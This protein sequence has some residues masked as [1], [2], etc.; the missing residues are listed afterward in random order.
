[1]RR[2][3]SGVYEYPYCDPRALEF[4]LLF[5][6]IWCVYVS[7]SA[8]RTKNS[9]GTLFHIYSSP[10]H[11]LLGFYTRFCYGHDHFLTS[12]ATGRL[13]IE[14]YHSLS[15]SWLSQQEIFV[16]SAVE[17]LSTQLTN[18]HRKSYRAIQISVRCENMSQIF[19]AGIERINYQSLSNLRFL[20]FFETE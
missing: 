17:Q 9:L 4:R 18:S 1:M 12:R 2:C 5:R 3:V 10:S 8:F 13:Q 6:Y 15:T 16:V 7:S 14:L 20:C 11:C 19:S